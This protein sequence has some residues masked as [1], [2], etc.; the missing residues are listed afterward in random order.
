MSTVFPNALGNTIETQWRRL[1]IGFCCGGDFM[2]FSL[3]FPKWRETDSY[4]ESV[5]S[6]LKSWNLCTS[7]LGMPR[8]TVGKIIVN[9]QLMSIYHTHFAPVEVM[10]FKWLFFFKCNK[11]AW[12]T[13]LGLSPKIY[14][15]KE[16]NVFQLPHEF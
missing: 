4:R 13:L 16:Q 3:F 14:N 12:T 1:N 7:T 5:A 15:K 9:T 11:W 10:Y 8:A 6:A 2:V